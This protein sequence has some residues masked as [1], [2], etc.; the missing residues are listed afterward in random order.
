MLTLVLVESFILCAFAAMFGLLLAAG[1]VAAVGK[2]FGI[3]AIPPIVVAFGLGLAA[4][5]ALVSGL[6]PGWRAKQL[7][8]V[9]ALAGR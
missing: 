1:I 8:I 9:D 3:A 6:L 4:L 2:G 5:L 7:T